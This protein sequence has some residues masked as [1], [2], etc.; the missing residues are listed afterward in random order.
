MESKALGREEVNGL[1]L[2]STPSEQR[3]SL[4]TLDRKVRQI[5]T[6]KTPKEKA[7]RG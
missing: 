6:R 5:I 2:K 4:D 3:R 7:Q 1:N